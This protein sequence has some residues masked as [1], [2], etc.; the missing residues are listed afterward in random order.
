[1]GESLLSERAA[2][3]VFGRSVVVG[4]CDDF[5]ASSD[6]EPKPAA[7]NGFAGAFELEN[8]FE[9]DE[10]EVEKGFE[11]VENEFAEIEVEGLP[12][13]NDSPRFILGFG[14][15]ATSGFGSDLFFSLAALSDTLTPRNALTLP[16]VRLHVFLRHTRTYNLLSCPGKCSGNSPFSCKS[17]T[18]KLLQTLHFAS[19]ADGGVAGSIQVC[20]KSR[21]AKFP[22]H[23]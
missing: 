8:G 20:E 2:A 21:S 17:R 9:L 15:A 5:A 19:A 11:E 16:F 7:K 6:T 23:I 22:S 3:K 13:N 12:P 10:V 4:D 14:G 1:L 18:I